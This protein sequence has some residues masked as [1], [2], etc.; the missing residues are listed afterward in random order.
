M[1]KKKHN[2][3]KLTYL[4]VFTQ[5]FLKIYN[6]KWIFLDHKMCPVI[7]I[8]WLSTKHLNKKP[9]YNK[10]PLDCTVFR[11]KEYI[12]FIISK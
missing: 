4:F 9:F 1:Y 5:Y 10:T 8:R 2:I 6:F 7:K 3:K 12:P 11:Q